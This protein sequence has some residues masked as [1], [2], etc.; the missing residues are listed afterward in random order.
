MISM[1]WIRTSAIPPVL[2]P[3][4]LQERFECPFTITLR[5]SEVIHARVAGRRRWMAWS[6]R[7]A[8]RI[9]AVSESLRQF[10]ISLGGDPDRVRTIPNGIDPA[11]FYPRPY[12][13]TRA[14]LGMPP[15]RPVILSVGYLI[16]GK[17]HHR[18][19]RALAEMHAA[20][21]AAELWIIGGPGR[22]SRFEENIR[23]A[24]HDCGLDK[25]THFCGT[26]KPAA[27]AEYMSAADVFCLASSREGWPN[28]V[29]E[30]LGCGT[31]V[32]ATNV[33]GIPDMLP[34]ADYGFIIP[35]DSHPELVSAL[36]E[37]LKKTWDRERIAAW[38][39]AR[40]WHQVAI[41][42]AAVLTEAAGERRRKTLSR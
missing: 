8:S 30:A 19:I 23:Q 12:G 18:V 22:G 3:G 15:D 28:V 17:G 21:I 5:G 7:R 24:V 26:L 14:R 33:G 40:S 9:I 39:R 10:A 2:R 38:G 1:S 36:A 32:V 29:H 4:W 27:V 6:F 25:S 11:V 31:P 41:E 13:E 35:A 37:A 34:S 16:E 42:T 20:G